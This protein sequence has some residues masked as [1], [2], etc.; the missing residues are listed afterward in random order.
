M[1]L[2]EQTHQEI[3]RGAQNI[4]GEESIACKADKRKYLDS[5]SRTSNKRFNTNLYCENCKVHDHTL[6][7]CWKVHGHPPNFNSN[8]VKKENNTTARINVVHSDRESKDQGLIDAKLT[9]E[10]F[11]Q[12]LALLDRQKG[13]T[14]NINEAAPSTSA[15]FAGKL[16][17]AYHNLDTWIIDSGASDHISFA[18]NFFS[19]YQTLN[20][21]NHFITVPY[22]RRVKVSYKGTVKL[23]AGL[24]LND[25]LFV[26][27]FNFNLLSVHKLVLDM[28][29]KIFFLLEMVV[30]CRQ[31]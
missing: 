9:P 19:N 3:S 15:H 30:F 17:L 26:P 16:C 5:K 31:I 4:V 22:G 14:N 21:K 29:C 2:Q 6:D 11:S 23:S 10:Q 24:T 7:R 27:D 18:I 13:T 20:G 12:L 28:K 25:G 1:L 8:T